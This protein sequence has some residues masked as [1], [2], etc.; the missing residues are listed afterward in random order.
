MSLSLK[1]TPRRALV[2]ILSLLFTAGLVAVSPAAQAASTSAQ[3]QVKGPGSVYTDGDNGAHLVILPVSAGSSVT[4]AAKVINTG[5]TSAQYQLFGYDNNDP[6]S[7]STYTV[8]GT[9]ANGLINSGDGYYT[10]LIAAGKSIAITVKV[11][12]N[13]TVPPAADGIELYL[14]S[15]DGA[16]SI[17]G[18]N[19]VAVLKAPSAATGPNQ[20]FV[21]N[22]SSSYVG[23]PQNGVGVSGPALAVGGSTTFTAHLVNGGAAAD[24]IDFSISDACTNYLID[25]KAGS[26]DV[27][28]AVLGGTY[29]TPSLA[30]GGHQDLTV[31][32]TYL[33]VRPGV[34]CDADQ[35]YPSGY[36][37]TYQTSSYEE[38]IVNPTV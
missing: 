10:P 8:N 30:H 1:A 14:D 5:T 33:G 18:A 15:S 22:G 6:S 11:A 24:V 3:L 13:K 38:L 26:T 12:F 37:E 21:K 9:V 17:D 31:K 32:T 35:L 2:P 23:G 25:V 36:S 28:T 4:F 27:T 34:P 7:V 29:R 20:M 16:T 19:M